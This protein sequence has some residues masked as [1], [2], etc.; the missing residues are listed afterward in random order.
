MLRSVLMSVADNEWIK[1]TAVSIPLTKSVVD[2]F[3]AG[4]TTAEAVESTSELVDKGLLVTIDHLGE[5]T[6]DEAAADKI[7]Q[8]YLDL[9]AQISDAGMADR[10]EVSLKLTAMG[11][12]L[13]SS[14]AQIALDNA[15]RICSAARNAGTTVTLDAEDYTTTD[16]TLGVLSDLRGDFPQTGAVIQAYLKR[17]EA[18][19]RDLATSGSRVRL[20]KGAYNESSG[21][22]HTEA[23]EVDRA[24][25]R[26]QR[27][28]M[29][30]E[31]YP[32]L[33]THDPRLIAIGQ[34]LAAR[35]NRE[36]DSFEFQMLYGIRPEEQLRLRELGHRVRIYVPYGRDW[37]GYLVRRMAEKPANLALFLRGLVDK[38]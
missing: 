29:E 33:A 19:C 6:V 12:S 3:V 5:E 22:A 32:M 7:V 30:G 34:D 38:K 24:Y 18:D 23:H 35:T 1:D 31:G 11:L 25:V 21:I 13:G 2:R 9:I 16:A 26:C 14:G 15:R 10:A 17:S 27:I 20:C 36:A 37:Y 28:L 4:E 8:A